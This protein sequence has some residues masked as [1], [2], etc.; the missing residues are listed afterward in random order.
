MPFNL[1]IP[2]SKPVQTGH[3][4]LVKRLSGLDGNPNSNPV[5]LHELRKWGYARLQAHLKSNPALY[6]KPAKKKA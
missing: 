1:Q 4:K 3:S 5:P 6:P 2:N